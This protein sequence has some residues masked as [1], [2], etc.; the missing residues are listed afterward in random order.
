MLELQRTQNKSVVLITEAQR[1][2]RYKQEWLNEL[3]NLKPVLIDQAK[4]IWQR[5]E[6]DLKQEIKDIINI[7][8]ESRTEIKINFPSS[9]TRLDEE[10]K[11]LYA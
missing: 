6:E 7:D 4:A 9:A 11:P 5:I 10:H 1:S 2:D 3:I 8:E